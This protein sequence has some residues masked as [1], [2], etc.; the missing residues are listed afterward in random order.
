M[1]EPSLSIRQTFTQYPRPRQEVFQPNATISFQEVTEILRSSYNFE[2]SIEATSLDILA[3]YL[4]GQKIIYTESKTFCEKQLNFLMLPAIFVA[5]VCSILNFILKDIQYGVIII[6]CLNAFNSFLLS[7]ISYL[8]LDGKA[9]AHKASAYKFQKLESLCEFHSGKYLFFKESVNVLSF[10]ENIE[11]EVMEI[12]ESNQ[13]IIPQRIRER[14]PNIYSTN[15]FALVKRVQNDEILVINRLKTT[16][17]KLHLVFD[18]KKDLKSIY[19]RLDLAIGEIKHILQHENLEEQQRIDATHE[20]TSMQQRQESI[21]EDLKQVELDIS[22]AEQKK[23]DAFSETVKHRERYLELAKT[24]QSDVDN[25]V[26]SSNCVD[27]LSV[28]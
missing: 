1:S 10:L 12:R 3:L 20:L 25:S 21:Q 16:V 5:A 2:E 22:A 18:K 26:S 24:F 28:S 9:E 11:K 8:K 6:S 19:E 4:K 27:L 23:D 7:L 13:F 15:V 17:Q 14:F